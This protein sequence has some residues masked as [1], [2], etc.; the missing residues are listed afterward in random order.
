MIIPV[1]LNNKKTVLDADPSESLLTVLRREKLY[2]VKCGCEKGHC[3][4]CMVLLDDDPIPSCKISASMVREC[5][6]VTL[7]YF[8][9]YP[10]YKDIMSGFNEAG[11]HLCGYCDAGKIFTA[12]DLLRKY[13]RVEPQQIFEA[14][15]NLDCCCTD[16]DTLVNGILYA[17]A[18]KHAREGKLEN[19]KK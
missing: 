19:G 14:I 4:N 17:V 13:R 18:A 11:I 16:R 9:N 2:K 3:G 5:R 12:Y 15:K 6:I 7:E 1:T 10:I 8:V